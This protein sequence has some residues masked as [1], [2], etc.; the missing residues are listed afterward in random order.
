MSIFT[1]RG[2]PQGWKKGDELEVRNLPG[3]NLSTIAI[4]YKKEV[5]PYVRLSLND[6]AYLTVHAGE[7]SEANEWM[8]WWSE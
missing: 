2:I 1:E 7:Q 8:K 6:I 5:S 4:I 3:E